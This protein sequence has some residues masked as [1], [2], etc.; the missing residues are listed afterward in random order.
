MKNFTIGS[1]LIISYLLAT[2]TATAAV[3][4]PWVQTLTKGNKKITK[5]HFY[6]HNLEGGPKANTTVYVVANASITSTS[7]ASF[8][9]LEVFDDRVTAG[10]DINS[11]QVAR[12]QGTAA[13]SDLHATAIALNTNFYITSG[14]FNRSTFGMTGRLPSTEPVREM[15][16]VGGTGAFRLARGYAVSTVYSFDFATGNSV[17]EYTI[18]VITPSHEI[19]WT[20]A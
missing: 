20:G 19:V 2:A 12:V 17:F 18:Y 4:G 6:V 13:N 7:R 9:R 16:V 8:G 3:L 15:P 5:F 14:E 11:E 10:P 1:M